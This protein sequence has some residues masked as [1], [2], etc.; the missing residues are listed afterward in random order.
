M[1][2]SPLW[3]RNGAVGTG[4]DNCSE[5]YNYASSPPHRTFNSNYLY[6]MLVELNNGVKI[7]V[8]G[9]GTWQLTPDEVYNAVTEALAVGYRHIDTAFAYGNEEPIGRAIR[10]L[11]IPRNEL[12][13]TTKLWLTHHN[14]PAKALD[15][16]LKNLGLDYVD[17]YLV[18]WPVAMN[19]NGNDPKFPSRPDGT[20]DVDELTNFVETWAKMQ[21][22]DPKKVRAIGVLNMLISNLEK[23]LLAP[24]TKVVPVVNQVELHPLLPQPNLLKWCQDHKIYLEAYSPLGSTDSPLLSNPTIVEMAEKYQVPP[25]T[26]LISWAI[27]RKTIVLP[28]LVTPARIKLNFNVA[29][30]SEAD[31]NIIDKVA[32]EYGT[33]R[34]VSPDWG[35]KIFDDADA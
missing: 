20:R 9:L 19:P 34:F 15:I 14:D 25:A 1:T 28:K 17:L 29:H 10:D 4:S 21:Q 16:S 2:I 24:L 31:G 3:R 30:L 13:V 12:F 6:K 7:P 26:V 18:H 23:L 8:I 22:L 5:C 35:V 27:W 33:K 32:H 11:V